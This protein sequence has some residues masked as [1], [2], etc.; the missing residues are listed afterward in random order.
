MAIDRL[1]NVTLTANTAPFAAGMNT[2]TAAAQRT[3]AATAT[4]NT[5]MQ[6]TGATMANTAGQAGLLRSG[7][8]TPIAAA[9]AA[10][11]GTTKAS[12]DWESSWAGVTKTVDG[13]ATQMERLE[14]DLRN[15]AKELPATHDEIAG[16]AEAAGQLGVEVDSVAD[17]SR[18]MVDLGETTNLS[19]EQA[20]TSIARLTNI[21]GT[22]ED[23]VENLGSTLVDLGNNSATTEAEILELGTRLAAA[24]NIA[25]LSESDVLAFAATLTSVGVN[26]EAGGTALS[27]VFTSIRDAV[28]DGSAELDTFAT[29]AGTTAEQFAADFQADPA[30]AIASFIAGLGDLNARGESTTRVFEDLSLTDQRLMRALLS[31]AEAGDLLTD[32]IELGSDAWDENLALVEEA[33]NRYDTTAANLS[34]N[35]NRIKDAAIDAGGPVATFF[36]HLVEGAADV[37]EIGSADFTDIPGVIR[38]QNE[39]EDRLKQARER[40]NQQKVFNTEIKRMQ[41]AAEEAAPE[42]D[43][44]A[45]AQDRLNQSTVTGT[46][47]LAN[48]QDQLR[49]ATDPVFDLQQKLVAVDEAQQAYD[50]TLADSEATQL[51]VQNAAFDLAEAVAAAE[52]AAINGD[53]SFDAF[54]ARLNR[55]VEQGVITAE[56]ADDIRARVEDLTGASEDYE[57]TYDAQ[58]ESEGIPGEAAKIEHLNALADRWRGSHSATFISNFVSGTTGNLFAGRGHDGGMVTTAGVQRF[59]GGGVVDSTIPRFHAGSSRLASDEVPAILQTGEMVLSRAQVAMMERARYLEL[60]AREMVRLGDV[61]DDEWEQLLSLGWQGKAGDR[62]EALYPPLE[63]VRREFIKV[64][65][66]T[67]AE[68]QRLLR[69]G[70]QGDAGDRMEALYPPLDS[71][72]VESGKAAKLLRDA[73]LSQVGFSGARRTYDFFRSGG[74][75]FA[76]IFGTGETLALG[77]MGEMQAGR[78]LRAMGKI[79][80]AH[81]GASVVGTNEGLAVLQRGEEVMSAQVV[82][83]LERAMAPIARPMAMPSRGDSGDSFS[84]AHLT[85]NLYLSSG[86]FLG[87]VQG[88]VSQSISEHDRR[89]GARVRQGTGR[90]R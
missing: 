26:A 54:D 1:V 39:E 57:G 21:M 8:T 84:G 67:K 40:A 31:T 68:W 64:G 22:S 44:L 81:D 20:A 51:D 62:M 83:R 52:Q 63:G 25:G 76:H 78:F 41:R 61:T 53:L 70:W 56:A 5:G 11:I 71:L 66:V 14:G 88:Q 18:T 87:V 36:D 74:K 13:S 65:E 69:L 42:V 10:I 23:E 79:P 35:F 12:I 89:L 38:G 34:R 28:V 86:E 3:T 16:V 49:G 6:R 33:A 4:M 2:A 46:E 90:A 80:K 7:L 55:W 77:Q 45:V 17:F 73:N 50:E 19:S 85:G 48:Y 60:V 9:G 37:I 30:Q 24:G 58:F 75:S 59:H 27:K 43:D 47:S 82:S 15:M 32:S 72:A 29:V